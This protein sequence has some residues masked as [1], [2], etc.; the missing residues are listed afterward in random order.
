MTLLRR[1]RPL[2]PQRSGD[3]KSTSTSPDRD[4]SPKRVLRAIEMPDLFTPARARR[5]RTGRSVTATMLRHSHRRRRELLL[6]SADAMSNPHKKLYDT[7]RWRRRTARQLAEFP[8]CAE[9]L[10]RGYTN[11]ATLSHHLTDHHGD[12]DLFYYGQLESLCHDCHL[13]T[14]GRAPKRRSIGIDGWPTQELRIKL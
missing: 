3:R 13:E 8:L 12:H 4:L 14:H 10:R 2:R 5:S 1:D 11:E 9:C 7:R 6:N